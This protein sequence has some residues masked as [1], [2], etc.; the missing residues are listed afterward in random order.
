MEERSIPVHVAKNDRWRR[1]HEGELMGYANALKAAYTV[2][3][4][5]DHLQR[6]LDQLDT[7]ARDTAIAA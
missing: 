1:E 7:A 2:Q 5:P 3:P 4:L 6:L